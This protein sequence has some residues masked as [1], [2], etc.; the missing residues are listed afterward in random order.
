MVGR[1]RGRSALVAF[2]LLALV[3]AGCNR[4]SS[5]SGGGDKIRI[6]A[7]TGNFSNPAVKQMVDAMQTEA[8]KRSG[9][10]LSVQESANVEEQISKAQTMIAQGIKV[11]GIHPWEGEAI[12]AF[13]KQ[14]SEKGVKFFNLI[15]DVPGAVDQGYAVSYVSG[16]E[17]KGGQLVGQWMASKYDAGKIAIITGTPGNFSATYRTEGFKK[18]IAAKPGL[19]VVAESTADWQRDKALRVA[20]DILTAHPD[21][22]A[23]FANNDEMAFGA[24]QA[25]K[26]VGKAGKVV[27]MGYNGT[28]IGIEATLKGQFAADGILPIPQFGQEFVANAVKA[29]NGEKVPPMI[30]PPIVSID[31]AEAKAIADGSK[32]DVDAPLKTR[33]QEAAQ[34]KCQ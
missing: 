5:S 30:A 26:S 22:I 15:D 3:A 21:L 10:E 4:G 9:V 34:S 1:V 18:G 11:I 7:V 12:L 31:T 24:L 6:G 27:V 23:I 32:S 29:A 25:L 28:C 13:E 2:L 17:R 20:T 19:R 33:V 8:K 14:Q 16:D